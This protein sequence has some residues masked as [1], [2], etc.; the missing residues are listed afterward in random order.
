MM[1][2]LALVSVLTALSVAVDVGFPV[3]ID[4]AG[5]SAISLTVLATLAVNTSRV[6]LTR[7]GDCG[8]SEVFRFDSSHTGSRQYPSVSFF[9]LSPRPEWTA[10]PDPAPSVVCIDESPI[11]HLEFYAPPVLNI[12][13]HPA[14]PLQSIPFRIFA[15][16]GW[17]YQFPSVPCIAHCD[18]GINTMA[19]KEYITG[20]PPCSGR[21]EEHN[22]MD[23]V[24]SE[25]HTA[26]D[27]FPF[28]VNV[29]ADNAFTMWTVSNER[30][31]ITSNYSSS[32]LAPFQVCFYSDKN[33]NG[34]TYLGDAEFVLSEPDTAGLVFFLLFLGVALPLICTVTLTLH[35]YKL[36]RQRQYV[37]SV[38][39][40]IQR[41]QLE[42]EL[43]V[44]NQ[45][46][47][48]VT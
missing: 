35:C 48:D 19:F 11:G 28:R 21:R 45:P 17:A 36:K 13:T 39:H 6:S 20:A 22:P 42:N 44:R 14:M 27:P 34:G 43:L 30:L 9:T 47:S 16:F 2:Y 29:S 41:I 5:T 38:K 37:R 15:N 12:T 7:S 33:M 8:E 24:V 18:A 40:Y 32:I 1:R 4:F 31:Q 3:P 25:G 46:S 10:G 23:A 26:I